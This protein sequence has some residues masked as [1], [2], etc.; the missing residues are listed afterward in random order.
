MQ[1]SCQTSCLT[2]CYLFD[3]ETGFVMDESWR[4][5]QRAAALVFMYRYVFSL[6]SRLSFGKVLGGYSVGRIHFVFQGILHATDAWEVYT[7]ELVLSQNTLAVFMKVMRRIQIFRFRLYNCDRTA[8]L[9]PSSFILWLK[10]V[11]TGLFR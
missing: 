5:L 6:G 8:K 10:G 4:K 9:H 3:T 7:L 1:T 11:Q 2:S